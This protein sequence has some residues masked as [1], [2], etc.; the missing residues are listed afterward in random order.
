MVAD[1]VH[2]HLR[3]RPSLAQLHS[4]GIVDKQHPFFSG[5]LAAEEEAAAEAIFDDALDMIDEGP[6]RGIDGL[7]SRLSHAGRVA[8]GRSSRS[9]VGSR[10]RLCEGDLAVD[11]GVSEVMDLAECLSTVQDAL[12][13]LAELRLWLEEEL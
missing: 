10:G 7:P 11:D 4:G 13:S 2:R 12:A 1:T 3:S 8:D 6:D 5:A 9:S